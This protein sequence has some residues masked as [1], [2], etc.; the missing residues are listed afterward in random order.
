MAKNEQQFAH[1]DNR[2]KAIT[3]KCPFGNC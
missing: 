2:L 1:N 3:C